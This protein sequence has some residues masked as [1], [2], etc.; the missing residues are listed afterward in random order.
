VPVTAT[1]DDLFRAVRLLLGYGPTCKVTGG[2]EARR[3]MVAL[4]TALGKVY[5]VKKEEV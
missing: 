1:T 5:E 2:S 3:E 4:V